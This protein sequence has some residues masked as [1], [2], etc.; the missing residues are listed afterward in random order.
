MWSCSHRHHLS[1][2][3]E[4]CT[5]ST[6]LGSSKY[7][8]SASAISPGEAC[9]TLSILKCIHSS[10]FAFL[11]QGSE[12]NELVAQMDS[13]LTQWLHLEKKG[14]ISAQKGIAVE[15]VIVLS[16]WLSAFMQNSTGE[17]VTMSR[18][19]QSLCDTEL[20]Y[21]IHNN[22]LRIIATNGVIIAKGPWCCQTVGVLYC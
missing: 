6:W 10:S 22:S 3:D 9:D 8:P 15:Y 18:G 12:S 5:G 20:I 13:S 1:R 16:W 7:A 11:I 19:H 2:S 17:C 21:K 14:I 4:T